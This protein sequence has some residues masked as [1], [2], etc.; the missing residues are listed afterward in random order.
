METL[1]MAERGTRARLFLAAAVTAAIVALPFHIDPVDGKLAV[2]AAFAK[3]NNGNNGNHGT[4]NNGNGN[5]GSSGN[6]GNAGN[7]GGSSGSSGSSGGSGGSSGSGSSSGDGTSS[8]SDTASTSSS[9]TGATTTS[10][11]SKQAGQIAAYKDAVKKAKTADMAVVSADGKVTVAEM[12]LDI[13]KDSGGDVVA[14]ESELAAAR[15]G[16]EQAQAGAASAHQNVE[17]AADAATNKGM[18]DKVSVAVDDLL[19]LDSS[20]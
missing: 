20:L 18:T 17:V 7:S 12:N 5:G 4:G 2:S 3:N 8:S 11:T 14:A 10:A 16:L 6:S 13:A 15:R 19:G 9:S 1:R